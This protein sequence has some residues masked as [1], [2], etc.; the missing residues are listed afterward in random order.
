[1]TLHNLLVS[2]STVARNKSSQRGFLAKKHR[3]LPPRM[4]TEC[5]KDHLPLIAAS[6]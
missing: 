5:N 1:M 3:Q 2:L 4:V 6:K